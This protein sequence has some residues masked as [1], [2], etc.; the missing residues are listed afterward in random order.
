M[1]PVLYDLDENNE[2]TT[3]HFFCCV[4]CRSQSPYKDPDR[5]NEG[6]NH[7]DHVADGTRC[8]TCHR[9]VFYVQRTTVKCSKCSHIYW[10]DEQHTCPTAEYTAAR[11][12]LVAE[13]ANLIETCIDEDQ[14]EEQAR[15][16]SQD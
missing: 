13:V 14:L 12:S 1:I 3:V 9:D 10:S 5:N 16:A 2:A 4:G 8:E 15:K 11:D 7:P 6:E